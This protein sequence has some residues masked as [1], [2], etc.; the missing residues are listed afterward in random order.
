MKERESRTR[1]WGKRVGRK[2]KGAG[3][4]RNRNGARV[5]KESEGRESG[6]SGRE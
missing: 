2:R 6:A 1:E 3:G 4:R 5:G